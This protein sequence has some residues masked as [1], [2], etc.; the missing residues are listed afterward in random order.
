M[1]C[2]RIMMECSFQKTRDKPVPDSTPDTFPHTFPSLASCIGCCGHVCTV[3]RLRY[4]SLSGRHFNNDVATVQ[5]DLQSYTISK[6]QATGTWSATCTRI[7]YPSV[8]RQERD[9][10]HAIHIFYPSVKRQEHDLLCVS[11]KLSNSTLFKLLYLNMYLIVHKY[12]VSMTHSSIFN[13][14]IITLIQK[15][16][17][18]IDYDQ[19]A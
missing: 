1:R 9:L 7:L 8:K 5:N 15:I 2:F 10:L 18:L 19:L 3:A 13:N 11:R 14:T 12:D 6:C 16:W 17:Q 4:T